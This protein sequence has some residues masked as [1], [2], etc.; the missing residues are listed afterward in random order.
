MAKNFLH[1]CIGAHV[2]VHV[3]LLQRVWMHLDRCFE[4]HACAGVYVKQVLWHQRTHLAIAYT[5]ATGCAYALMCVHCGHSA[6]MNEDSRVRL[7]YEGTFWLAWGV[8]FDR[9]R[10]RGVVCVFSILNAGGSVCGCMCVYTRTHTHTLHIWG[11]R[12]WAQGS[13][14]DT[15]RATESR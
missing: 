9:R 2:R 8:I 5:L 6:L 14:W 11:T 7:V 3:H 13:G 4:H 15:W 12:L 10:N 1:R